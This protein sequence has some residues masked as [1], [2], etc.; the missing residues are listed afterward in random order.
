MYVCVGT[1]FRTLGPTDPLVVAL[2][3]RIYGNSTR[4]RTAAAYRNIIPITNS[5]QYFVS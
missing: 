4:V 2:Y 5:M 3:A 1:V